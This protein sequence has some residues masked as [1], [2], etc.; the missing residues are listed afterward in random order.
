MVR[1]SRNTLFLLPC[2]AAREL[3]CRC[4]PC[5]DAHH[6]GIHEIFIAV[7]AEIGGRLRRPVI[8]HMAGVSAGEDPD[9]VADFLKVDI[10]LRRDGDGAGRALRLAFGDV[11]RCADALPLEGE[12]V[13][14]KKPRLPV[15]RQQRRDRRGQLDRHGGAPHPDE[16]VSPRE[17]GRRA[18]R[19]DR[20]LGAEA[21][22]VRQLRDADA[23][24][25]KLGNDAGDAGRA[26]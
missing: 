2:A 6:L 1:P 15:R 5:H 17:I 20:E 23:G 24:A 4:A 12:R 8:A 11:D 18:G 21:R 22:V 26:E 9:A 14:R 3:R 7:H 19:A 10:L 13:V 16:G 25:C